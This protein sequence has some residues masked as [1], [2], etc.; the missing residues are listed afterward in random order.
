VKTIKIKDSDHIPYNFTGIVEFDGGTVVWYL[1]GAWHRL[2][3]PAFEYP[4]GRKAWYLNDEYMTE[5]EHAKKTAYRRT[6]LG[7]LIFN[8]KSNSIGG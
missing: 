2:D 8:N 4:E 6:T 3:G 1:K 7:K 5:E